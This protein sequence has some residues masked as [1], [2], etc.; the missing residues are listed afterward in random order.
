MIPVIVMYSRKLFFKAIRSSRK[1]APLFLVFSI[2]GW[3][4]TN[5]ERMSSTFTFSCVHSDGLY[6]LLMAFSHLVFTLSFINSLLFHASS[7]CSISASLKVVWLKILLTQH[8]SE[9]GLR[10]SHKNGKLDKIP[11]FD[12]EHQKN[13]HNF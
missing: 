7:L 2:N 4:T 3:W 1:S 13:N 9:F 12:V 10:F 5:E 11:L 6:S 8:L